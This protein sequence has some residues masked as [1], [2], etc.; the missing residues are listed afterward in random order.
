MIQL[1]NLSKSFSAQSLFEKVS[2]SIG[3]RERLGFVGRNGSGKSTLFKLIL[4]DLA[5]DEGDIS[6]P[7]GYKIRALEQHIHF[8]KKTVMEECSDLGA[9]SLAPMPHEVEKILFGLGLSKEDMEKDPQ[10]FSGGQQVRIQLAKALLQKP[11]LL[12]LDEPTNYLDIVSLRWLK[13][14]L[15]RFEGELLIITHD[16]EFMDS[17]CT[18]IM[19]ITRK[20]IRKVKGQ[21]YKYYEQI[22]LDE[23]IYEKTRVNQNKK[24]EHLQSFVDRFGAK[25]TKAKAAQS[26]LKQLDKMEVLTELESEKSFVPKF[27]FKDCPGKTLMTLKDLSF[28]YNENDV[29]FENI[30]FEIGRHDRI[31]IIGKN[32][33]GKSTLLNVLS[34]HLTTKTGSIKEHPSLE[35]G[36]FGQTNIARLHKNH[37][38][39]QEISI[40][41]PELGHTAVRNICGT[42]M[43]EGTLAEKKIS[44]LSGGEQSRVML[45][46]ILARPCNLL[47]L[48]EPTNHLDMQSIDALTEAMVQYKGALIIVTHSEAILKRV[49][50]KLIVFR[51]GG[52]DFIDGGYDYFLEKWGWEEEEGRSSKKVDTQSK[53]KLSKMAK[54]E[55]AQIIK[56]RSV[57]LAPYKLAIEILENEISILEEDLEN[58][59]NLLAQAHTDIDTDQS[60]VKEFSIA[61]GKIH[62]D[63]EKAFTKMEKVSSKHDIIMS[64]YEKLLN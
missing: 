30:S 13:E 58:M 20:N 24:A 28:F 14:F 31:G 44:V 3:R 29:L 54:K 60:K 57:D 1:N 38:I 19:G 12:L 45:G 27:H 15:R 59:N 33:K 26:R 61:L 10:S 36:H 18:H 64:D 63:I 23:E 42:M 16:R 17:V 46:K 37:S 2:L 7:K 49:V 62:I 4:G 11:N 39:I 51:K 56:K 8:T 5:A 6:I 47:L 41:N 22:E 43:F 32:G 52:A 53:G 25:A 48:D 35:K 9:G 34:N 21:T 55:R 40:S 50:N